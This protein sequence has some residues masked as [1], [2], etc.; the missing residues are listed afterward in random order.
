MDENSRQE[1]ESEPARRPG[2]GVALLSLESACTSTPGHRPAREAGK[3]G[4]WLSPFWRIFGATLLSIAA[5]VTITVVQQF[6]SILTEVRQDLNRLYESRGE[7]ARKDEVGAARK[8]VE[9]AASGL[10]ALRERSLLLEQQL[11][12][13]GEERKQLARELQELREWRA[14]VAGRRGRLA[15]PV[16]LGEPRVSR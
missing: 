11:R 6:A 7:L 2:S 5:L 3:G 1:R 9:A 15:P 8:D 16:A 14:E 10:A 13:A 12:A 4:A